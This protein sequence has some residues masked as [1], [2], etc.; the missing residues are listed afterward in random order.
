MS[1]SQQQ[2]ESQKQDNSSVHQ[3]DQ[4]ELNNP[5][6]GPTQAVPFRVFD[7]PGFF[8]GFRQEQPR[9]F[10]VNNLVIAPGFLKQEEER[11]HQKKELKPI[12]TQVLQDFNK[13]YGKIEDVK[14]VKEIRNE[15]DD[16]IDLSSNVENE[17]DIGNMHSNFS[18][19]DS[20]NPIKPMNPMPLNKPNSTLI[21][22]NPTKQVKKKDYLGLGRSKSRKRTQSRNKSQ[23]RKK[24]ANRSTNSS[25]S[26]NS[27]D[28]DDGNF[29]YHP[30]FLP[31]D[32]FK[33][34][35][36]K[37]KKP[38]KGV[39]K[40][41]TFATIKEEE[42]AQ[43]EES[44]ESPKNLNLLKSGNF[45]LR[46]IQVDDSKVQGN[47]QKM[48]ENLKPRSSELPISANSELPISA[49]SGKREDLMDVPKD[50]NPADI[51]TDPV[52][53]SK[54]LKI[55]ENQ[56][57]GKYYIKIKGIKPFN[58]TFIAMFTFRGNENG[59]NVFFFCK[60]KYDFMKYHL[61]TQIEMKVILMYADMSW[62]NEVYPFESYFLHGILNE[63]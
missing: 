28:D 43:K 29:A 63:P 9:S 17:F 33:N 59:K 34:E 4:N 58:A 56:K 54:L 2:E 16:S 53:A 21:S 26:S 52:Y 36:K 5:N 3:N 25:K 44:L 61:D 19:P 6:L 42:L 62:S 10:W 57:I 41:N 40:P 14:D 13:E 37:N 48:V 20:M 23:N 55:Y 18:V 12:T 60:K 22:L 31:D 38:K 27:N 39:K 49:N 47:T 51:Y 32:L 7:K 30:E 15:G 24:K 35:K 1:Q 46:P 11:K 50:K 45:N 8:Q